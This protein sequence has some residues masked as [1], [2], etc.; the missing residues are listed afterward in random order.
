MEA[1]F[2]FIEKGKHY[3]AV[4]VHCHKGISRS[5]SFVIGYLMKKNEFTFE[6]ALSHVQSCRPIVQPNE[7][8]LTQLKRYDSLL[9]EERSLKETEKSKYSNNND[10]RTKN[11]IEIVGPS[12]PLPVEANNTISNNNINSLE[13]IGNQIM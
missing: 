11:V 10:S 8:F 2:N 3:G 5:A 1:A 4:L 7:S 13:N 12:F 9:S 6:E